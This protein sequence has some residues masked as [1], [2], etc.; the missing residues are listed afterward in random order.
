MEDHERI[1]MLEEYG[2]YCYCSY[3]KGLCNH[4]EGSP[5][6]KQRNPVECR[7]SRQRNEQAQT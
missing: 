7:N 4:P 3:A 1:K 2:A 6:C 5:E